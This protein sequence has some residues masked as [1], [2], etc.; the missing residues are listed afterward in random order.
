MQKIAF[1]LALFVG[2]LPLSAWAEAA[3]VPSATAAVEE[4]PAEQ[5]GAE[6]GAAGSFDDLDLSQATLEELYD[7]LARV[8]R[9]I[10]LLKTDNSSF[11][12]SGTYAVGT[13]IPVGVYLVLEEDH[14]IF[15]S[16]M[17]RQGPAA[18]SA[19]N[20]YEMIINQAVIQL[21]AGTYVT[22][23]DA[24]AYPFDSAPDAGLTKGV[25]AEGGYWVGIQIPAGHYLVTADEKAP[26]SSFS[27]YSGVLGTNAQL[28]R[29][30]L[31]YDPIE[32]YLETGQYIALSGCSIQE[33]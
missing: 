13:D 28:L 12:A 6:E 27:L 15:P 18:E 7:L 11:Y 25:G 29:F 32:L 23:N 4:A 31:V 24:I 26:L 9:Q 1:L 30:E 21:T 20:S 14:A 16:V 3:P 33:K 2:L 5:A 10:D 8:T 19:L 17:V 22:F